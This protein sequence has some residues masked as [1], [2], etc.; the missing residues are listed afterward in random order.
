MHREK[1]TC[2]RSAVTG[3]ADIWILLADFG[4]WTCSSVLSLR[5]VIT[6]LEVVRYIGRK[7]SIACF[8]KRFSA[9]MKTSQFNI[10]SFVHLPFP[11]RQVGLM[12][13]G[14]N[15]PANTYFLSARW[16]GEQYG[17][18]HRVWHREAVGEEWLAR[19]LI[20]PWG[21]WAGSKE[22]GEKMVSFGVHVWCKSGILGKRV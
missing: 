1:R 19:F 2:S 6:L 12:F 15:G 22:Q 18:L 16:K 13:L 11:S 3:R 17:R 7:Q 10:S 21:V 9:S 20:S 5:N 8:C 14:M 4:T